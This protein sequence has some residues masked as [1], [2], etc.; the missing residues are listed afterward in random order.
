MET[1]SPSDVAQ[2]P[3]NKR[4]FLEK[5]SCEREKSPRKQLTTRLSLA[6]KTAIAVPLN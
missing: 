2:L 5:H 4:Y 1:R 6:K 3:R